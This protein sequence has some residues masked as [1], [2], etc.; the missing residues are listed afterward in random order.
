[1]YYMYIS[2]YMYV[3]THYMRKYSF[4][5]V[6]TY[7]KILTAYIYYALLCQYVWL[8]ERLPRQSGSLP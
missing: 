1:M 5:Y 8:L 6:L 7:I 2:I 4:M 3:Y